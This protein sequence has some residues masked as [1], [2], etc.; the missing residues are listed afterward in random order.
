MPDWDAIIVGGGPAGLTAGLYLRRGQQHTLLLEKERTGGTIMNVEWIENYPGFPEGVNGSQLA[1][2]MKNQAVKSGLEI[3]KEEVIEL[4]PS[5]GVMTLIG[6]DDT[7]YTCSALIL[8]GGAKS[9][10][11]NVPGE[12]SLSGKGVFT[13]AFC[14]GGQFSDQTVVVCGSGDSGVTEAL[15][16]AQIASKVI[17]IEI[18]PDITAT[19]I[20]KDRVLESSKIKVQCG[21]RVKSIVG[22]EQVKGIEYIDEASGQSGTLAANGVLVHVGLDPNTGYLE[23]ILPLDPSGHIKVNQ[24]METEIPGI[25]AAGDIRSDSPKQVSTAVGDGAAAAISAMKFLQIL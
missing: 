9:K 24:Y 3:T 1:M 23:G 21:L 20:L 13:C 17:L 11:L 8:A 14:D 25:F 16:L 6:K 22:T 19:A 7:A 2:D 12:E 4:Q 18:L 5:P 15:Y 10:K